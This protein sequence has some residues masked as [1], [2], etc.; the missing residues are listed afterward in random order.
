MAVGVPV[1]LAAAVTVGGLI[2]VV[3]LGAFAARRYRVP[4][5]LT[6]EGVWAPG[7]R[8]PVLVR[9]ADVVRVCEDRNAIYVE[10]ATRSAVIWMATLLN[11]RPVYA[12]Q[13]PAAVVRF[14]VDHVPRH[15][16]LELK[17]W[18]PT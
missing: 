15:A 11:R 4:G 10:T 7:I 3:A 1:R 14:I 18:L 6:E 5:Q 17:N 2:A 8:G 12:W 13:D 16:V 9:W